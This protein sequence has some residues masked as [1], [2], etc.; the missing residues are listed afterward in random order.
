MTGKNDHPVRDEFL[1]LV[2]LLVGYAVVGIVGLVAVC[3]Q[4]LFAGSLALR[5]TAALGGSLLAKVVGFVVGFVVMVAIGCG[6]GLGIAL[7]GEAVEK[8]WPDNPVKR[9]VKWV[10]ARP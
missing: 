5:L 9:L 4:L 6:V 2:L 7:L 10:K 3:F 8:R 1:R